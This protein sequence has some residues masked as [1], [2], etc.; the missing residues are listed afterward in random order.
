MSTA[1]RVGIFLTGVGVGMAGALLYSPNAGEEMRRRFA[2]GATRVN[3]QGNQLM[4]DLKD[5]VTER[6]DDAAG[7]AKKAA[8]Q[9]IDKSK[10][11]AHN[12]GKKI[13]EAGKKLQ[14]V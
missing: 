2:K 4:S 10:D 5:K 7:A 11:V 6:I 14:E 3:N 8:G 1:N 13:E 9:V 12:A